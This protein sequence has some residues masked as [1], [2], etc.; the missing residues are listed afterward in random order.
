[1]NLL[2]Y[3]NGESLNNLCKMKRKQQKEIIIIFPNV[4]NK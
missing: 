1:M 4:S 3:N 2:N